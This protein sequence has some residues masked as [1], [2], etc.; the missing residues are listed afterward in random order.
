[1]TCTSPRNRRRRFPFAST[2]LGSPGGR[3]AGYG[4]TAA[5]GA[6]SIFANSSFSRRTRGESG[7]R[8]ASIA[9][10]RKRASRAAEA[11]QRENSRQGVDTIFF[12]FFCH[13]VIQSRP[14]SDKCLRNRSIAASPLRTI[15][16]VL[17][18][19]N[20]SRT[21]SKPL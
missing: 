3:G 18:Y 15:P 8:S 20:S 16:F 6:G 1:V 21:S 9:S 4:V 19:S 2:M 12:V 13:V 5:A 14:E 7:K 11:A 10:R 17:S